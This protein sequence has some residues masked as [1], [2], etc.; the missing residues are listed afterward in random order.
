MIGRLIGRLLDK[1]IFALALLVALQV[2]LLADHYRQFLS[3]LYE[4][5]QW[6]VD[7]YEATAR[8]HEYPDLKAMID[9]H[10]QNNVPS[11]RTDAEQKLATLDTLETLK[12]GL[13]L[14]EQGNLFNKAAYMFSPARYTYLKTVL[15]NFSPG[16]P[17]S[18]NGLVFGVAVGL[19]LNYL[20]ILPFVFFPRRKNS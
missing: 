10:L 14:F 20:I 2:P 7:G 5:T 9:H 13:L 16:V 1:L 4:S 18:V 15:S 11:V 19:I 8:Q 12:Q 6:Q 3:G 17:L